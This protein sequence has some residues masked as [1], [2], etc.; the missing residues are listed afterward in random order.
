LMMVESR[1]QLVI[2]LGTIAME[3]SNRLLTPTGGLREAG[4]DDPL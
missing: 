1:S 3:Q 2:I 4:T